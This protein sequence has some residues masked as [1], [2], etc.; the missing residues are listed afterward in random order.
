MRARRLQSCRLEISSMD[1][2]VST[3]RCSTSS[4][5]SSSCHRSC[6]P[7]IRRTI[8]ARLANGEAK[9]GCPAP[10]PK[11]R[12]HRPGGFGRDP[13]ARDPQ[14]ARPCTCPQQFPQVSPVYRVH[15]RRIPSVFDILT[16]ARDDRAGRF[17]AIDGRSDP[18]AGPSCWHN[19]Q[20]GSGFDP[21][22]RDGG[23]TASP[24]A[25][26]VGKHLMIRHRRRAG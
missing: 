6:C 1:L 4:S 26:V 14:A 18:P 21:P 9:S 10:P 7:S 19:S 24:R 8:D 11:S 25:P 13:V 23:G 16:D 20:Q 3:S 15:R 2:V 17:P 22:W 5:T 12:I